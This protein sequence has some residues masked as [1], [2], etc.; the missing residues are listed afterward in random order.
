MEGVRRWI[1]CPQGVK[2]WIRRH[3]KIIKIILSMGCTVGFAVVFLLFFERLVPKQSTIFYEGSL[4]TCLEESAVFYVQSDQ[5]FH[6]NI[7]SNQQNGGRIF[8]HADNMG[9]IYLRPDNG[10]HPV[11][12]DPPG[13]EDHEGYKFNDGSATLWSDNS[14]YLVL[15]ADDNSTL[16]YTLEVNRENIGEGDNN[17]VT[18]SNFPDTAVVSIYSSSGFYMKGTSEMIPVGK[19][20]AS[21]CDAISFFVSAPTDNLADMLIEKQLSGF[22]VVN[23]ERTILEVTYN[24]ETDFREIGFAEIDGQASSTNLRLTI[25]DISQFPLPIQVGGDVG[26]LTIAGNSYYPS[27]KQWALKNYSEILFAML[28]FFFTIMMGASDNKK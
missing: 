9:R 6:Y 13:Q 25:E 26:K 3:Q 11:V 23:S 2:E 24:A 4:D 19:Y 10:I 12:T 5:Q 1:R 7:V 14:I 17:K 8:F 16:S 15:Q 18:I 22:H 20:L 28:G 27:A 21:G